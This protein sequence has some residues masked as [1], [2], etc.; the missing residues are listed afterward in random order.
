MTIT[1]ITIETVGYT[2][3]ASVAEADSYLNI[4]PTREAAWE[5]LS[6]DNKGK[7]LISAT[8]RLDLFKWQGEKTGDEDVQFNQ[9]PRTGLTYPGGTAV[10]TSEVPV[11]VENATILLAGSIALDAEQADAG[12]SGSNTKR[13]KAGSAEVEFFRQV[14]GV[15]LQDETA[16]TLIK[17]FL[18]LSTVVASQGAFV[19]GNEA[20]ESTF[21]D[22][23]QWGRT[24]GFP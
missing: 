3:Y 24:R 20:V 1:T 6:T 9:W 23:D 15:A 12:S 10:S 4:D 14:T 8:R 17:P 5:A 16:F 21:S 11:E 18:E 22:I 13:V 2:S 19:S 7:K